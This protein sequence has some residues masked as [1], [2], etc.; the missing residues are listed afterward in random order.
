MVT[1]VFCLRYLEHDGLVAFTPPGF[2]PMGKCLKVTTPCAVAGNGVN[3]GLKRGTR[4]FRQEAVALDQLVFDQR[5]TASQP[6]ELWCTQLTWCVIDE[7]QGA[8]WQ[9]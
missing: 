1:P 2:H 3:A 9:S 6:F 5:G 7:A 8:Q 4:S